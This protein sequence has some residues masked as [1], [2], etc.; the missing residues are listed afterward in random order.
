VRER[1][2][3]RER[4]MYQKVALERAG[5]NLDLYSSKIPSERMPCIIWRKDCNI[6]VY[7]YIMYIQWNL[8]SRTPLFTNNSVHE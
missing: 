3:E 8:G 6:T 5:G 4:V 2:R 1:E 7:V